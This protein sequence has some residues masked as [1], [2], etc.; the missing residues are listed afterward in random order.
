MDN[1][2]YVEAVLRRNSSQFNSSHTENGTTYPINQRADG[3]VYLQISTSAPYAGREPRCDGYE[4]NS[5]L[6]VHMQIQHIQKVTH[7]HD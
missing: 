4:V 6:A 2:A 7:A 5:I 1:W 3:L